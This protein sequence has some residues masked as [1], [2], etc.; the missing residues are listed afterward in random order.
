MIDRI[1]P[2]GGKLINRV[3]DKKERKCLKTKAKQ[4][5]QIVLNEREIS[6]VYM[7]AM[8]CFSPLEG[9]LLKSDYNS[10]VENMKL[11]NGLVWPL[12]ITLSLSSIEVKNL[13][14]GDEVALIGEGKEILGILSIEEIY[15]YDKDKEAELVYKTRDKNHPG[16]AYIYGQGEHLVG[17]KIIL[18]NEPRHREFKDYWFSPQL[19]RKIFKEKGWIRI[20]G[21]QT[22]NPIHRAHEFIIKTALE[23]VDGL[24]LNPLVGKTKKGDIPANVR[25]KCYKALIEKYFPQDRV[26]MG[27][28]GAAM[29]YAGPREAVLHALVRKNFGCTHFIV[30]RDHA[31]VGNY[32][33]HFDAQRIFDKFKYDEI[34]ITPLFFDNAFYCR[35]CQEMATVKT[36]P[37]SED[38]H[39]SFSGTKVRE[40]LKAGEIPPPEFTRPEIANILLEWYQ[41]EKK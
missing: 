18:L 29:R 40:L 32:Y 1:P 27:V 28:Y 37:H 35:K 10:V 11:E 21:F 17:G 8:G 12:P 5:K 36:C 26:V 24:F 39:L 30:G 3:A 31:G 4:L 9:F 38:E 2:H 25:M 23:I 6:D 7:I 20:V 22:R 33:G 14:E 19:V 34:G 41:R 15:T 13:K 16:V